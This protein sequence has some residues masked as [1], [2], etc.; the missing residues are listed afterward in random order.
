MEFRSLYQITADFLEQR[1]LADSAG[2][3]EA[4]V[5]ARVQALQRV[6]AQI[7]ADQIKMMAAFNRRQRTIDELKKATGVK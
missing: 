4:T 2:L 6:R 1:L 7:V 3:D 5:T